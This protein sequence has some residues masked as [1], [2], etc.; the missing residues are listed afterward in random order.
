MKKSK[1]IVVATLGG[2]IFAVVCYLLASSS[3]V[4]PNPVIWQIITSRTLIGFA[5]GISCISCMHWS[6]H[7]LVM[8]FLFSLPLAFSGLMAPNDPEF[9]KVSMFVFT[10]VL[11]ML[12]GFLIE[13]ITSVIFKAPSGACEVSD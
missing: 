2:V 13:L 3:T 7:G 10:I 8:G 9:S 6:L 1:R 11:G 4:L 12:Y 5:I